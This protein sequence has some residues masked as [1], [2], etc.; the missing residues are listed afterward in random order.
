[1]LYLWITNLLNSVL[2]FFGIGCYVGPDELIARLYVKHCANFQKHCNLEVPKYLTHCKR[3]VEQRCSGKDKRQKGLKEG[4][5]LYTEPLHLANFSFLKSAK[6]HLE[7]CRIS[8]CFQG[9]H[10]HF[11]ILNSDHSEGRHRQWMVWIQGKANT[12]CEVFLT[13]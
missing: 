9:Y 12:F 10:R 5:N 3:Q 13:S 1:M 7:E 2:L 8:K 11:V 4:R 6:T